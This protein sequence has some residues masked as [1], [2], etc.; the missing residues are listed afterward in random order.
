[1]AQ[2]ETPQPDLEV[3]TWA[4]FGVAIR[5][6]AEA[7]AATGFRP[8]LVLTIARG[9]LTVGGTLAYALGTKNCAT[10]NVQYYTGINQR[11]DL[12]AMLPPVPDPVGM[13]DLSVLIADDVADSGQTLAMVTEFC[14]DHVR[15][16][17]TSVLY[18][19]PRSIIEPDFVWRETDRWI[20]FPWSAEGPVPGAVD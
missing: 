20:A 5:D 18:R 16:A 11:L 6:L 14:R 7:I 3:L 4:M 19:K 17:R 1:M 12:P 8:D 10:I 15:E 2:P 13:D 9:G